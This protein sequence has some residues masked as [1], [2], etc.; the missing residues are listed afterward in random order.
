MQSIIDEVKPL[1]EAQGDWTPPEPG[2]PSFS[3]NQIIGAYEAGKKKGF[4]GASE[5]IQQMYEEK[6]KENRGKAARDT[7]TLIVQLQERHITLN[8]A[9][10]KVLSFGEYEVLVTLPEEVFVSEQFVGAFDLAAEIEEQAKDDFYS[11]KF[12]FSPEGEE[13]DQ[14]AVMADGYVQLHKLLIK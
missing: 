7:A 9:R 12:V 10:L 13:F 11:I 6:D 14:L 5:K 3:G 1:V 8:S 4:E 2:E